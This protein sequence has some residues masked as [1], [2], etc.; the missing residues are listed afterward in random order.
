[1]HCD[2][3][4]C[5]TPQSFSSLCFPFVASL[6]LFF[7]FFLPPFPPNFRPAHVSADF[8]CACRAPC[9]R[10]VSYL[11][12]SSRITI[13]HHLTSPRR[14]ISHHIIS[15]PI[16]SYPIISYPILSYPILSYPI[17]SYHMFRLSAPKSVSV[18]VEKAPPSDD[19]NVDAGGCFLASLLKPISIIVVVAVI[20]KRN[21]TD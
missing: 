1:M 20:Y 2:C 14:I 3:L 17:L 12:I 19:A 6:L 7:S 10:V 5:I 16:I 8:S 15:Y 18:H 21:Q 11:I 9:V 4:L 13:P